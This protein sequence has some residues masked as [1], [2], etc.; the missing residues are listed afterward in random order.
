MKNFWL[1]RRAAVWAIE[2][3]LF[4]FERLLPLLLYPGNG[5]PALRPSDSFWIPPLFEPVEFLPSWLSREPFCSALSLSFSLKSRSFLLSR[6]DIMSSNSLLLLTIV[7]NSIC[8]LAFSFSKVKIMSFLL[9]SL[10]WFFLSAFWSLYLYM[11]FSLWAYWTTSSIFLSL[12]IL[13]WFR[14]FLSCAT[15]PS[16]SWSIYSRCCDSSSCSLLRTAHCWE[17]FLLSSSSLL[18]LVYPSFNSN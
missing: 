3:I 10:S 11:S 14:S 1:F 13:S 18:T 17:S 15:R 6:L 12:P 5:R 4:Y 7:S 2:P 9:A 8:H 16:C